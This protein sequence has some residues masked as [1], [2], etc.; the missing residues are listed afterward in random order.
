MLL[1]ANRQ[2]QICLCWLAR[3]KLQVLCC[4][5]KDHSAYHAIIYHHSLQQHCKAHWYC[6]TSEN[7]LEMVKFTRT[8]FI[9]LYP[10]SPKEHE[11]CNFSDGRGKLCWVSAWFIDFDLC[12]QR[13]ACL[14][15]MYR[16]CISAETI[17][18]WFY[19]VFLSSSMLFAFSKHSSLVC[20]KYFQWLIVFL[21]KDW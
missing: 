8:N 14:C 21:F 17:S 3:Q 11:C 5:N 16:L 15:V 1:C 2:S 20:I 9:P 4:S 6:Q 10:A 12:R 13:A 18:I 19:P 7:T